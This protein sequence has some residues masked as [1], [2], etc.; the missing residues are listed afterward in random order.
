MPDTNDPRRDDESGGP[1]HLRRGI[2]VALALTLAGQLIAGTWYASAANARLTVTESKATSNETR[3]TALEKSQNDIQMKI[4][5]SLTDISVRLAKIET[6][7]ADSDRT[8]TP[9]TI[10]AK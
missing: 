4:A 10:I 8:A 2:D 3:I 7:L 9:T 1:F 5:N 6:H